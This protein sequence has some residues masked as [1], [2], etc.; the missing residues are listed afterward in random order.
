MW[1]NFKRGFEKVADRHDEFM[2]YLEKNDPEAF[3]WM[4][5]DG[6]T[7]TH[8]M[9]KRIEEHETKFKKGQSFFKRMFW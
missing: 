9:I 1:K 4:Q 3:N 6:Q 5:T 2:T 8:E 7:N